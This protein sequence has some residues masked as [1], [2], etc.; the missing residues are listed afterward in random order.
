MFRVQ[1]NVCLFDFQRGSKEKRNCRVNLLASSKFAIYMRRMLHVKCDPH[2]TTESNIW[3]LGQLCG[4]YRFANNLKMQ[5]EI[6]TTVLHRVST[7][8]LDR[9]FP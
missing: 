5:L 7:H 6:S 2:E 3:I 8:G 1:W 9:L 4:R